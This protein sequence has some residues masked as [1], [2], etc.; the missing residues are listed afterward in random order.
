[1]NELT[2]AKLIV[3]NRQFYQTFAAPFSS[4]RLRLQPGVRRIIDT[5]Q[6][7]SSILDLGCGNGY[8]ASELVGQEHEFTYVGLDS[9]QGLLE[10]ARQSCQPADNVLFLHADLVETGWPAVL[11]A[12]PDG[13]GSPPFDLIISFAFLHHV[14]SAGTRLEIL[15]QIHTLLAPSG[16]FIHSEWQ[17]LNNPRIRNRIQPWQTIG[18]SSQDVDTGDYLLD[19][20]HGGKGLRY[21]HEF[22]EDELAC[23]ASETQFSVGSTFYSDGEGGKQ[24]V[25]QSWRPIR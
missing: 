13:W 22:T 6:F 9:S 10:I 21:V 12:L 23:L 3:L 24:S 2:A 5:L 25:Y 15:R 1:M 14:P 20:R 19:W 4:T 18:M 11:D 8:F 17:F 16:F 7:P